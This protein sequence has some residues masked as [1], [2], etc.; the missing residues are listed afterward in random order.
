MNK[1]K[2]TKQDKVIQDS[3]DQIPT[4]DSVSS[5]RTGDTLGKR[6][7]FW[8]IGAVLLLVL[9]WGWN[10]FNGGGIGCWPSNKVPIYQ[11]AHFNG[12]NEKCGPVTVRGLNCPSENQIAVLGMDNKT[13]YMFDEKGTYLKSLDVEKYGSFKSTMVAVDTRSGHVFTAEPDYLRIKVTDSQGDLISNIALKARPCSV[14]ADK[15][16]RIWVA[17]GNYNFMQVFSAANGQFLGD[18][19]VE[20]QDEDLTYLDAKSLCLAPDGLLVVA[21]KYSVWV[22]RLPPE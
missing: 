8:V 3:V 9:T 21:D 4:L 16:G 10:R 17:Y 12:S 2:K 22:Y 1:Q 5:L 20:N 7:G 15:Q 19:I 11:I 18:V 6:V 14:V 13:V